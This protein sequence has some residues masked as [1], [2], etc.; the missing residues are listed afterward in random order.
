MPKFEKKSKYKL[1]MEVE[2]GDRIVSLNNKKSRLLQC[3]DKY[4]SIIKAQRKLEF[5]IEL[6]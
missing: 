6:P 4:G 1:D 5:H 2:V 3:I